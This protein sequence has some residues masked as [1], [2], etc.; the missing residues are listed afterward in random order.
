[1]PL[2]MSPCPFSLGDSDR[3]E[4]A[5]KARP[6][7]RQSITD[8][9]ILLLYVTWSTDTALQRCQCILRPRFREEQLPPLSTH[10]SEAEEPVLHGTH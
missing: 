9:Q 3:V 6:L 7:I 4:P 2:R 5:R 8:G 10:T 1:M